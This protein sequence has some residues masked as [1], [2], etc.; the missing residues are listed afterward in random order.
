MIQNEPVQRIVDQAIDRLNELLD[1]ENALVKSPDTILLGPGGKLDS[2]GFVNLVAALEEELKSGL[3]LDLS[4]MDELYADEHWSE[5]GLTV[6]SLV[7][8]LGRLTAEKQR[9]KR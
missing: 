8:L 1:P 9:A 4:M 3:G 7:N 5:R 6:G 2:M